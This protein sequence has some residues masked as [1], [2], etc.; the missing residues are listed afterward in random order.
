MS[1]L[2]NSYFKCPSCECQCHLETETLNK[3]EKADDSLHSEVKTDLDKQCK[4]TT[5]KCEN[6]LI[7]VD[8]EKETL[9]SQDCRVSSNLQSPEYCPT[10]PK[11]LSTDAG[12]SKTD[13]EQ[14]EKSLCGE[15]MRKRAQQHHTVAGRGK[16][17]MKFVW[18]KHMLKDVDTILHSHW[19]LYITHG[20]I[21]QCS[22]LYQQCF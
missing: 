9:N 17:C 14:R 22:I 20:F 19:L 16:P 12:N 3:E 4:N 18:N 7:H 21:G 5:R 6:D 15:C 10:K 11:P 1:L 2:E 13:F 8:N